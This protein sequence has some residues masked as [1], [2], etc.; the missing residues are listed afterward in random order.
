MQ[1]KQGFGW[2]KV[3]PAALGLSQ[4]V[5]DAHAYCELRTYLG[6]PHHDAAITGGGVYQAIPSPLD[7]ANQVCVA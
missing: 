7:A 3:T 4:A 2:H 6:I 5:K 1:L